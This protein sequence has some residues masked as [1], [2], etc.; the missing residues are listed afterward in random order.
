MS[1]KRNGKDVL[2]MAH[3]LLAAMPPVTGPSGLV[4]LVNL[5]LLTHPPFVTLWV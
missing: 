2:P 4:P 3:T 1:M 5:H